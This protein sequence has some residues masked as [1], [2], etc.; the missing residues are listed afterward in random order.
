M[1]GRCPSD[2]EELI[3]ITTHRNSGFQHHALM[4]AAV[5]FLALLIA[6]PLWR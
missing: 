5:I 4:A 6:A 3:M 2:L 1:T